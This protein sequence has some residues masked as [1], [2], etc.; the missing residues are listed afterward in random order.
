MG[1]PD[2]RPQ[3]VRILNPVRDDDK[4]ILSRFACFGQ[5]VADLCVI[6]RGRKRSNSLMPVR[7]ANL[8]E[9]VLVDKLVDAAAFLRLL[10]DRL[11]RAA[12]EPLLDKE[13]LDR[14]P[15]AKSFRYGIAAGAASVMTAGTQL[16][17]RSDFER[18]LDQVKIQEV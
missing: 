8:L 13:F 5:D 9:P 16:I 18:L 2:D 1:A 14:S 15:C 10:G 7:A 12:V 3:I 17:V 4:R 6:P 11:D